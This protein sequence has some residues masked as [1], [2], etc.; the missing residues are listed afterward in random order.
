MKK[1][2]VIALILCLTVSAKSMAENDGPDYD[3]DKEV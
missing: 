1:V 3:G 2:F